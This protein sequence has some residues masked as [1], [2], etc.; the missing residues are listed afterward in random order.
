MSQ[1]YKLPSG[2]SSDEIMHRYQT[3]PRLLD[4]CKAIDAKQA[5]ESI[6]RLPNN[7][8]ELI[9]MRAA[10]AEAEAKGG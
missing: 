10:I 3:W 6:F 5:D 7:C 2:L 4:A 1:I 8:P 9:Q